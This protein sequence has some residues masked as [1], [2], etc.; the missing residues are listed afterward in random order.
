MI[1]R[2]IVLLKPVSHRKTG[3]GGSWG[4]DHILKLDDEI[5]VVCSGG[6]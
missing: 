5:M 3:L 4:N 6:K 1:Y 2:T